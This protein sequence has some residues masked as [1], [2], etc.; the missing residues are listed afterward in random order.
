MCGICGLITS[1]PDAVETPVRRMMNAMVHRGPDDEGFER[2]PVAGAQGDGFVGFG[3][4]RLSILDLSSNGH[5][6]MRHPGTGDCL[7]FNGEVYNFRELR[8]E[9]I[10]KGD[11]FRSSGD[12]E[13]VLRALARWGEAALPRF[14]GMYG[15][16]FYH[17]ASRRTL[18]ARDPLGIK[19]LYVA[20]LPKAFVFASE[21][22][23]IRAS[24]LVTNEPDMGGI[25][26]MLAYGAVQ[27][28]R[29]VWKQIRSFPAGHSQWI[30]ADV[31]QGQLPSKPRPFWTMPDVPI[32]ET[33]ARGS[34]VD[35]SSSPSPKSSGGATAEETIRERLHDAVLRHLVADVQV[36]VFLSAGID[37]TIMAAIARNYTPRITAFT[38]GFG[39]AEGDDET[40]IATETA[41]TLG[42]DHVAVEIDRSSLPPQWMHW[43]TSMD[44]PS[45]DGFNSYVVSRRLAE[46]GIKVGLSGLGADE[47][48]GGYAYF[49]QAPRLARMLPALKLIPRS[50]RRAALS[51]AGGFM[52]TRMA[53]E[54]LADAM[55]G[56]RSVAAVALALRRCLTNRQLGDLGLSSATT[57]LAPD[58]LDADRL[59]PANRGAEAFA[60]VQRGELTHYMRDTLLRDTDANSMRHSLEV[61]VPFL[62]LPLVENVLRLPSSVHVDDGASKSLLRRSCA[63]LMPPSV[64]NRKKTGFTLPI[65][66]WMRGAM[67]DRCQIAIDHLAAQPWIESGEVRGIWDHFQKDPTWCHWSRPLALVVLGS[68][69]HEAHP[70]A[71]H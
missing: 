35:T 51:A 39:D 47:L 42:V 1:D 30:G 10:A 29:T 36:G 37:S 34:A 9:L 3:F 52:S 18:L 57:G 55:D 62:D 68:H 69:F 28:P 44:S 40:G 66:Q 41:R 56:D 48:F 22:Q 19:P 59:T 14:N 63:S 54:K 2:L 49:S 6:P 17:A 4:R 64:A 38:V 33:T 70:A 58:F 71:A 65:G 27:S 5:Q 21:I 26:G 7:I 15:L 46:H 23:T 53:S 25:A 16:A 43:L 50:M 11:V 8:E 31:A 20:T 67:R 12:T 45:I 60:S 61:R 24:G 13:V 32:R